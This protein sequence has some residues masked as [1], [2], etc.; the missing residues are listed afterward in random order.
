MSLLTLSEPVL[1]WCH[2]VKVPVLAPESVGCRVGSRVNWPVLVQNVFTVRVVSRSTSTLLP[3]QSLTRAWARGYCGPL[4]QV[5]LVSQLDW[6]LSGTPW[7]SS[8]GERVLGAGGWSIGGRE[9][10]PGP[11]PD[12]RNEGAQ[13]IWYPSGPWMN[14]VP[15]GG[16]PLYPW[17]PA[18]ANP[19]IPDTRQVYGSTGEESGKTSI[20]FTAA[21]G[22]C[23]MYPPPL[24]GTQ[25]AC[26]CPATRGGPV[27]E[28]GDT[29]LAP[30]LVMM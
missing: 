12:P 29:N 16:A 20:G 4:A 23:M 25:A 10:G 22:D 28:A 30:P 18:S 11:G 7:D 13:T 26:C 19:C 9:V 21:V 2:G 27:A 1:K 6:P 14:W 17:G 3:F 24:V 5:P 8:A 15:G